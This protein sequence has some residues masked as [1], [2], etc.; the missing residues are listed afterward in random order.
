MLVSASLFEFKYT[1]RNP[2]NWVDI[3]E[4]QLIL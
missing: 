3:T 4:K 2:S 1:W